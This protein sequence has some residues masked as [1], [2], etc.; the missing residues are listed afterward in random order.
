MSAEEDL[1]EHVRE[2][3]LPADAV[4]VLRGGSDTIAKLANHARRTN[5]LY[6]LDGAPLWGVSVFAA[7]DDVGPASLDKLL[8]ERLVSYRLV[9]TPTVGAITGAGFELL[10]TFNRPHYTLLLPSDSE[11][12]LGRLLG[13]LGPAESNPYHVVRPRRR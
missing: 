13:A 6:S 12:A 3:A 2:E 4:V 11:L 10:P 9:H 1:R 7:L 8:R 5:R